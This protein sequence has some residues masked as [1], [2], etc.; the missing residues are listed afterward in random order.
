MATEPTKTEQLQINLSQYKKL[1]IQFVDSKGNQVI[2]FDFF[3]E[4]QNSHISVG[5]ENQQGESVVTSIELI[6]REL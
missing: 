1:D 2:R 6:D 3:Q 5:R 4:N